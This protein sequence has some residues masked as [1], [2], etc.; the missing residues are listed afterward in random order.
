MKERRTVRFDSVEILQRAVVKQR[1]LLPAVQIVDHVPQGFIGRAHDDP[2]VLIHKRRDDSAI[3]RRAIR[4]RVEP[5]RSDVG[6]VPAQRRELF[7]EAMVRRT[8][9]PLR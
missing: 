8:R 3:V 6:G 4:I 2:C 9:A 7:R 1:V 5:L